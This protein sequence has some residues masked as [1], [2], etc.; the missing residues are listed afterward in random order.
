[1]GDRKSFCPENEDKVLRIEAEAAVREVAFAV[2]DVKISDILPNT[3][4]NVYMNL[5]TKEKAIFCVEL[6]VQGFRVSEFIV[7]WVNPLLMICGAVW[8]LLE[9]IYSNH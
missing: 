2:D 3:D 7:F 9:I 5:K 4:E 6:S 1:M 8:E